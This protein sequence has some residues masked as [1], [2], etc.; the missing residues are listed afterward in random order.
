MFLV[1]ARKKNLRYWY[2][3][4]QKIRNITITN[5]FTSS[6]KNNTNYRQVIINN[7]KTLMKEKLRDYR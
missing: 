3:F 1:A 5:K 4:E 2:S 7:F 6:N